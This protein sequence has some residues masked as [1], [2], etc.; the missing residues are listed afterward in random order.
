MH[1]PTDGKLASELSLSGSSPYTSTDKTNKNI[2]KRNNAKNTVQTIQN[3]VH[4]AC[5]LDTYILNS[6]RRLRVLPDDGYVH[7]PKHVT[8]SFIV[9]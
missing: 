3:T 1:G 6:I 5:I 2:H 8:G 4:I 7:Q 9:V